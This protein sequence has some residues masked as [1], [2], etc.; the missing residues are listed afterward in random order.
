MAQATDAVVRLRPLDEADDEALAVLFAD[1]D[2]LLW[3]PGPADADIP[4]WRA[5]N[6]TPAPDFRTWA[7]ADASG[8]LVGLV[9]LFGIDADTGTA[10]IGFRTSAA[11]RG[12]GIA[13]RAVGLACRLTAAEGIVRRI[14]LFHAAGNVGSCRVAAANDF[15]LE[16]V[17]P[18]NYRYGD[19]RLHDEH[20]H[21]RD[22]TT[23][24]APPAPVDR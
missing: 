7:V 14:Q 1:P 18:A 19:G 4:Q 9:S 8:A 3:N 21:V 15:L 16:S 10:E 13:T 17:L 23:P 22:L 5:G 11:Q 2:T 20:L 24:P 12:R 6:A